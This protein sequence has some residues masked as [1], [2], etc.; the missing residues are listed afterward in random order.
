MAYPHPCD[1]IET[2]ADLPFPFFVD[3]EKDDDGGGREVGVDIVIGATV[4]ATANALDVKFPTQL[5]NVV[6][7]C[8]CICCMAGENIPS[9]I[10]KS[11]QWNPSPRL[12]GLESVLVIFCEGDEKV[13][14]SHGSRV[15]VATKRRFEGTLQPWYVLDVIAT[16]SAIVL[17]VNA[18]GNI[19]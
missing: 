8:F 17:E 9:R 6:T 11:E 15:P 5:A 7:A 16:R 14:Y 10:D 18:P 3:A 4:V 12:I 19:C 2:A 1:F 13:A